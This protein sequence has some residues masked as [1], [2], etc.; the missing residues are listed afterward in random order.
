MKRACQGGLGRGSRLID[1]RP[2]EKYLRTNGNK[3]TPIYGSED[4]GLSEI[5][6]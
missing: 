3:C 6:Q 5:V 1:T 2:R 4:H